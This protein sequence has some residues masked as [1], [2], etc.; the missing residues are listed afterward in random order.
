M[1]CKCCDKDFDFSGYQIQPLSKNSNPVEEDMCTECR[2]FVPKTFHRFN[3][4]RIWYAF[5]NA[6][7]G[8]TR[9]KQDIE[10]EN[11]DVSDYYE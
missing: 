5:E 3:E 7:S 10:Y 2:S 1:R 4:T 9:I 6:K 8:L 11:D